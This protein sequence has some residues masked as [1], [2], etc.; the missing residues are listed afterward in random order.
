MTD[1]YIALAG[2]SPDDFPNR[3]EAKEV[4]D[5]VLWLASNAAASTHGQLLSP[6]MVAQMR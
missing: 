4:A 5:D 3:R 6:E 2:M 1:D